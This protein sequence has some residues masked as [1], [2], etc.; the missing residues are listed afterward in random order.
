MSRFDEVRVRRAWSF[1]VICYAGSALLF[2]GM[3]VDG[4]GNLSQFLVLFVFAVLLLLVPGL[5]DY[6]YLASGPSYDPEELKKAAE[7]HP[8]LI[9]YF[10]HL[11]ELR[12]QALKEEKKSSFVSTLFSFVAYVFTAVALVSFVFTSWGVYAYFW[13][14]KDV[15]FFEKRPIEKYVSRPCTYAQHQ[16]IRSFE[17]I[18]GKT[19]RK[20]KKPYEK[21]NF[22]AKRFRKRYRN[23]KLTGDACLSEKSGKSSGNESVRKNVQ[24]V[25]ISGKTI[26]ADKKKSAQDGLW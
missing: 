20:F 3:F 6:E 4:V 13:Q 25:L 18:V 16:M 21:A 17:R 7:A 12:K 26:S 24:P 8:E 1:R 22:L 14:G 15:L 9:D 2:L 10:N 19:S 23:L 11:H 5:L